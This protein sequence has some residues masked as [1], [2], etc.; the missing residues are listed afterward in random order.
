MTILFVL[1]EMS[2]P[3]ICFWKPK[4]EK[5]LVKQYFLNEHNKS[6]YLADAFGQRKL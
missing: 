4:T 1:F 3:E 2:P 5:N 6:H